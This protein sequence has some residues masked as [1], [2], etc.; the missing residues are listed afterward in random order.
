MQ[1]HSVARSAAETEGSP[2]A[3]RPRRS[4][5][6]PAA[7]EPAVVVLDRYG[8]VKS[9]SPAAG[10]L[11]K[12]SPQELVGI[13]LAPLLPGLPLKKTTP[14][15]NLAFADFWGQEAKYLRFNGRL[16]NGQQI[17]LAVS[18]RKLSVDR[19]DLILLGFHPKNGAF[20]PDQ[21]LHRLIKEAEQR[22][23]SIM[24]TDA[25]GTIRFVNPAFENTTGYSSQEAI[26]RPAGILK[27]GL[28]PPAFYKDMWETLRAGN[29]YHAIFANRRK[30]GEI[31]H[32]YK[33]IRPF[34]GEAGT[35]THFVSTSHSLS[36]SLQTTL[37][38]LQQYAYHDALTAL[39]NRH[40]F[41]DRLRQACLL[42]A[43]HGSGF[44]L[45]Y[46]DLDNFKEIN[47]HHGHS[48]G[49]AALEAAAHRLQAAVRQE[50]TVAR[51]GGDE[52]A[53]ILLDIKRSEDVEMILRKILRSFSAG[54]PFENKE[55]ELRASFGVSFY[56]LNT[57][58]GETLVRQ[59]DRAMY[60]AKASGG[61][62]FRFFDGTKAPPAEAAQTKPSPP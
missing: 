18:L 10:Q 49:D 7:T 4:P 21:E 8:V 29:S 47:D 51:L 53:I 30:N 9:S 32:E 38:H 36:E 41:D 52:F 39:P 15:Y 19:T 35:T 23:D 59:A 54:I 31:F 60:E 58:N 40:L 43:R 33:D 2:F 27:S 13:E 11:F 24:I 55:I 16:P 17:P 14:D 20:E 22:N 48:A 45:V 50:D 3:R 5:Y 62:G 1:A 26:G 46:A 12:R 56:P 57:D 37:T 61:D 25:S 6:K 34:I 44:A 28:H 42:S